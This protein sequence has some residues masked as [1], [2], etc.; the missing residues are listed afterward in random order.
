M[1]G[2]TEHKSEKPTRRRLEKA[3]EKGQIARSKEVPA[4]AVLLGGIVVLSF[5]GRTVIGTLELEMR[6]L[7]NLRPPADI[8][9]PYLSGLFNGIALSIAAAVLPVLLAVLVFS[10]SANVLQGG[11]VFSTK[12]LTFHF[13]RLS[14]KHGLKKIF[15]KNGLVE[16]A[17]NLILLTAVSFICYKVILQH[18]PIYPRL[19]LMDVRKLFYWTSSIGSEIFIRVSILLVV[20]A[21]ADYLFQRYRFTEELKMTRQ[22]VK[23][24]YKETEGDPLIRGRIRRIQR[25]MSR[26]RMM[27]DVPTA[28]VVITNPTHYAIAL[29]YKMDS[30]E[31]PKVVA[32]G[33]GFLALRIRELA[34]Q[35]DVPIVENKPLARTLYKTVEIGEYIPASLYKAVAEILAYI[36]KAK[37]VLN[38]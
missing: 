15:S 12:A 13:E 8:T 33:V 16:L 18:M 21:I 35:H 2:S 38:R 29:S 5:F 19:V 32:K 4:A 10:V 26:K 37:A 14:P 3:R 17:K 36:Y 11:L 28:D 27:A 23:Q 22:E 25:E 9:V 7:F 20:V 1:S 31:A 30:M 6:R 34:Q 24:E